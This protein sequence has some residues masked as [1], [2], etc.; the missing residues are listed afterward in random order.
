MDF[1][2]MQR[3]PESLIL[4]PG[5][6]HGALRALLLVGEGPSIA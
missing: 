1:C 2:S 5:Q 4:L 3:E 6:P